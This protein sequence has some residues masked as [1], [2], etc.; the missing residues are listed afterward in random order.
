M[1][2]QILAAIGVL[3]VIAGIVSVLSKAAKWLKKKIIHR[4]SDVTERVERLEQIQTDL[5]KSYKTMR[6]NYDV[7]A[8]LDSDVQSLA[9]IANAQRSHIETLQAAVKLLN[10]RI[11][12]LQED[13][14]TPVEV[15]EEYAAL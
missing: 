7:V 12:R 13:I 3:A 14:E 5:L 11:E 6:Q 1:A 15:D 10:K 2:I 4:K 9:N 8:T